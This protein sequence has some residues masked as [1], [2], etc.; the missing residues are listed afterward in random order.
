V[1]RSALRADAL[2]QKLL[3]VP[4]VRQR[5]P[6]SLVASRRGAQVLQQLV[7]VRQAAPAR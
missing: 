2:A 3:Q 6:P 1:L 4:T 5:C 7:R